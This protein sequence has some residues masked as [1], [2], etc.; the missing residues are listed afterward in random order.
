[1]AVIAL[2]VAGDFFVVADDFIDDEAQKFFGKFWIKS[3]IGGELTQARNLCL[4]AS[5][6]RRR[7]AMLSFELPDR[8]RDSK[9]FGKD[10]HKGCINVIDALAKP[11]E[12]FVWDVISHKSLHSAK[13]KHAQ[14][15]IDL[16]LRKT[17]ARAALK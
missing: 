6:I 16:R 12:R 11:C 8:L 4:F 15:P 17:K 7:Q 14:A 2:P 10:V 3:G 9:P 5:G 1:M 13:T